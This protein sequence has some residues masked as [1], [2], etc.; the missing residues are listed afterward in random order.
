M[1]KRIFS[2][3][4]LFIIT[5]P[6]FCSSV[7]RENTLH[8]LTRPINLQGAYRDVLSIAV[9]P[10]MAASESYVIGMPF[11]IE[12]E[13]VAYN[14]VVTDVGSFGRRIATWSFATNSDFEINI[15]A[16]PMTHASVQN[17]TELLYDLGFAFKI[18]YIEN[19]SGETNSLEG[20]IYYTAE[21]F[22][23]DGY[24][25]PAGGTLILKKSGINQYSGVA[26]FSEL[27]AEA[28]PNKII[29]SEGG[30]VYFRFTSYSTNLIHSPDNYQ[31]A[32]NDL[33]TGEYK[34]NVTLIIRSK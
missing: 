31:I 10:I 2:F 23:W 29:G 30:G 14:A 32:S 18:A 9:T 19:I 6:I 8:R 20:L 1:R 12:D 7:S 24:N 25:I 17:G 33:P 22:S 28:A 16:E 4:Y 34:A 5:L 11:N 3:V 21:G 13:S 15:S 27:L 26:S